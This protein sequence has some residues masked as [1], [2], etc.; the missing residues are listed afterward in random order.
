MDTLDLWSIHKL[1]LTVNSKD[2]ESCY[3][4]VEN[5]VV[6]P[7]G[8]SYFGTFPKEQFF[9]YCSSKDDMVVGKSTHYAIKT[10]RKSS[11]Q[12]AKSSI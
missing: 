5:S 12:K 11:T 4:P 6:T 10:E 9:C 1:I 3:I 2:V 8:N 7:D